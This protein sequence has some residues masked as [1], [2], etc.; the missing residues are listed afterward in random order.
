MVPARRTV[1]YQVSA[2]GSGETR[3]TRAAI[4]AVHARP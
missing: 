2:R 3:E 4:D 1:V